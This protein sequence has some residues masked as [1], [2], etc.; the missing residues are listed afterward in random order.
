MEMDFSK[1]RDIL[2]LLPLGF[3]EVVRK[4]P[5]LPPLDIKPNE[6]TVVGEY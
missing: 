2:G 5:V 3:H 4:L 6:N 1:L